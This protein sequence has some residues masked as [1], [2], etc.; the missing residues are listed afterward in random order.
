MRLGEKI[1]YLLYENDITQKQFA[2]ELNIAPSTL[3]GYINNR[4]EPDYET[5][6]KIANR[7]QVSCDYLLGHSLQEYHVN[8][9]VKIS[10]EDLY[11]LKYYRKLDD[12]QKNIIIDLIKVLCRQKN[13]QPLQ[14]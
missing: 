12:A 6:L 8:A 14:T 7:L 1:F 10:R 5:L 11:I 4:R 2:I 3:S 9:D 13:S